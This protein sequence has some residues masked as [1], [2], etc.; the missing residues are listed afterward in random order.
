MNHLSILMLCKICL[1]MVLKPV[2]AVK[3][4]EQSKGLIFKEKQQE[5]KE[6]FIKV[7]DD[8]DALAN[9]R[10]FVLDCMVLGTTNIT[11]FKI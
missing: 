5:N 10:A 1:R 11:F 7:F 3:L 6:K 8:A 2:E 9:S 4:G